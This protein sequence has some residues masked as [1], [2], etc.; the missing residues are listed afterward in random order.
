MGL[1][2]A[3][4]LVPVMHK[5][6]VLVVQ[7]MSMAL[8]MVTVAWLSTKVLWRDGQAKRLEEG[9]GSIHLS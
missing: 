7:E 8:L 2:R 4:S 6:A 9:C 1:L 3:E 5:E